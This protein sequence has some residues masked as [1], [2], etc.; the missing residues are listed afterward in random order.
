MVMAKTTCMVVM[1]TDTGYVRANMTKQYG[2]NNYNEGYGYCYDYC[3]GKDY[4]YGVGYN[5]DKDDRQLRICSP[6]AS[7]TSS[8]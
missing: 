5:Y 6:R 2:H 8:L 3:Y 7:Q 1:K 4:N